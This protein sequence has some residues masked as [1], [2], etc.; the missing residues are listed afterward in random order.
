MILKILAD[1]YN[2]DTVINEQRRDWIFAILN[3]LSLDANL[4]YELDSGHFDDYLLSQNIEIIDYPS[5]GATC[6]K[7]D[8]QI[9]GEWG[10]PSLELKAESHNS[11]YYEISIEHWSILDDEIEV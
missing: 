9:I 5:I 8:G 10:C 7:H 3:H 1:R 6:I 4:F 11:F 2:T